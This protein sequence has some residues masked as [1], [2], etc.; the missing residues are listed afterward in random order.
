MAH[1]VTRRDFLT[2][3][4]ALVV[5]AQV[6]RAVAQTPRVFLFQGDSITD[7]GR[8]RDSAEPNAAGAAFSA[9]GPVPE[10]AR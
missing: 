8:N 7:C 9:D 10:K 6:P 1:D 2:T 3:S 5:A 4:A